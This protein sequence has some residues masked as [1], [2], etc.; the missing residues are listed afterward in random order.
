[1]KNKWTIVFLI[2]SIFLLTIGVGCQKK[3]STK[4]EAYED[5][6]KKITKMTSYT[7]KAD[8]EALG[9]KNPQKYSFIHEYKDLEH[10]K[11][12]VLEPKHLSGKTIE[13]KGNEIIVTNPNTNDK[14]TIPNSGKDSQHLFIGDFVKN[15]MQGEDVEIELDN[16]DLKLTTSI[17]GNTKYFSKQ[18]LYVDT[19]KS[20]PIKLEILDEEGNKRYKVNYSNFE[21]K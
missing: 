16:G 4:E 18:I 2:I 12:K 13:Y 14:I 19:N 10:F 17:P 1:M 20:Y 8:V 9:N 7:C 21:Y 6:Q 11:V 15:Y 3:E 5:F